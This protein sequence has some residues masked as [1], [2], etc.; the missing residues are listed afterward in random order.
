MIWADI[1]NT[2]DPFYAFTT[3]LNIAFH[4]FLLT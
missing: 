2:I 4:F 1:I 3:K